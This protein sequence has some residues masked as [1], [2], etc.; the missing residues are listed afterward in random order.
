MSSFFRLVAATSRTLI[1]ALLP[2]AV[3]MIGLVM[4]AGFA[5]PVSYMRGWAAWMRYLNPIYFAFESLVINEFSGRTF[6]CTEIIPSGPGYGDA[7]GLQISCSALGSEAGSLEVDGQ[8]Y[9]E[10]M[11]EADVTN[12]WS[13]FGILIAFT[14]GLGAFYIVASGKFLRPLLCTVLITDIITAQK[15]K[16]EVLVYQRGA[17][18]AE[19]KG[20]KDDVE[21]GSSSEKPKTNTQEGT[22]EVNIQRQTS[23]V[24]WKDVVYDIK[25]KG[26]ERRILDHVDGWVKPGTLT[27]LMVNLFSCRWSEANS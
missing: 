10:A 26:E 22:E 24:S 23:I 2:T 15:S 11:Y 7:A 27:A 12:K 1:Q 21:S 3:V 14:I 16:G 9:I 4:Y 20:R 25:I 19:M 17:I 6:A 13:N 18:P 8:R 5:I